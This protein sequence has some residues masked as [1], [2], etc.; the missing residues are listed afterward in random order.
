MSQDSFE[1]IYNNLYR[2]LDITF[3]EINHNQLFIDLF[4]CINDL[5]ND[6]HIDLH[7]SIDIKEQVYFLENITDLT[8]LSKIITY[9]SSLLN[10]RNQN[11]F[12]KISN[13]LKTF[14]N[15]EQYHLSKAQDLI[16]I[17][18]L[19]EEKSNTYAKQILRLVNELVHFHRLYS[20]YHLI[21]RRYD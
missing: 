6:G 16:S 17:W 11:E 7:K 8:D 21:L 15:Q 14:V 4:E 12:D 1:E 13:Q 2:K 19:D 9:E 3:K 5:H 18:Q 10:S 20:K